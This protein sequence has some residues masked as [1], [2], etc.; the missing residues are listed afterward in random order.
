MYLVAVLV[1]RIA[2]EAAGVAAEQAAEQV[3]VPVGLPVVAGLG[4][5]GRGTGKSALG[6][7]GSSYVGWPTRPYWLRCL[8]CQ[9]AGCHLEAVMY[10]HHII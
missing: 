10:D 6:A 3:A 7:G 4:R 8:G 2:V 5:P 1:V 9:A